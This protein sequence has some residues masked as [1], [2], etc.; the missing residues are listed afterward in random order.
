MRQRSWSWALLLVLVA[1][2]WAI[3]CCDHQPTIGPAPPRLLIENRNE[4]NIGPDHTTSKQSIEVRRDGQVILRHEG[5]G[6]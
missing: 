5:A 1:W 2:C 4:V 6:P 3:G